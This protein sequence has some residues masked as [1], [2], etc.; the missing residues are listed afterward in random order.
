MKVECP[1]PLPGKVKSERVA[2]VVTPPATRGVIESGQKPEAASV[3]QPPKPQP[4]SSSPA[5]PAGIQAERPA[6]PG[7]V[8]REPVASSR[9]AAAAAYQ[10]E[11]QALLAMVFRPVNPEEQ[12]DLE[13]LAGGKQQLLAYLRSFQQRKHRFGPENLDLF[14]SAIATPGNLLQR[15]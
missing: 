6:L 12:S 7:K 11:I 4:A 1:S 2:P 14:R 8:K 15:Y 9:Q 3:T 10:Q 5:P 13:T